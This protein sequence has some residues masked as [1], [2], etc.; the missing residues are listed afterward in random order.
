MERYHGTLKK[1]NQME[2]FE[3]K[4]ISNREEA[5]QAVIEDGMNLRIVSEELQNDKAIVS[6]AIENNQWAFQFAS[7]NLQK[8]EDLASR[9]VKSDAYY[10]NIINPVSGFRYDIP[11]LSSTDPKYYYSYIYF[12][13]LKERSPDTFDKILRWD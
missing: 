13:K 1:I 9:V 12:M 5:L 3:M 7:E 6:A 11:M 2:D 8:D 4:F 10:F